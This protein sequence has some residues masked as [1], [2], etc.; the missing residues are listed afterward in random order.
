MMRPASDRDGSIGERSAQLRLRVDQPFTTPQTAEMGY[1]ARVRD[2][3][4]GRPQAERDSVSDVVIPVGGAMF[5]ELA[6]R[7]GSYLIEAVTPSGSVLEADVEVGD[8]ET[9]AVALADDTPSPHEWL[10][11]QKVSGNLGGYAAAVVAAKARRLPMWLAIGG[12]VAVAVALAAA[13]MTFSVQ[14]KKAPA[15]A[16]NTQAEMPEGAVPAE[17]ET[18]P[19]DA[20]EGAAAAPAEP[21]DFRDEQVAVA[22]AGRPLVERDILSSPPIVRASPPRRALARP[23]RAPAAAPPETDASSEPALTVPAP[24]PPP[25]ASGSGAPPPAAGP[26]GEA[27]S[28]APPPEIVQLDQST[29]LP[30]WMWLAALALLATGGGGTVL[31]RRGMIPGLAG[32]ATQAAG[33]PTTAGSIFKSA[34]PEGAPRAAESVAAAAS[35][36]GRLTLLTLPTGA[37]EWSMLLAALEGRAALAEAY[38]LAAHDANRRLQPEGADARWSTYA[39]LP[40]TGADH[41][42]PLWA[43]DNPTGGR[44]EAVRL[45]ECWVVPETGEVVAVEILTAAEGNDERVGA[46]VR[47]PYYGTLLGYLAGGRLPEAKALLNHAAEALFGKAINPY[48]AAAGGYVLVGS[49]TSYDDAPWRGW[50]Q[51]LDAAHPWLPDA[52]VLQAV[53]M[54]QTR[55]EGIRAK[56]L[57]AMDRGVPVYTEGLKRL[58]DVLT[59]LIE[60]PDPDGRLARSLDA[61]SRLAG[62]CNP[63]QVFTALRLGA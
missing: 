28:V 37:G 13:A 6:V 24:P 20:S 23:G 45:P 4:P 19:Q 40:L 61:V 50:L 3:T 57:E 35:S 32:A 41:G 29:G 25:E 36:P 8:G 59:L 39:T 15:P 21:S 44:A 52:A 11:W 31:A 26:P 2:V 5:R 1:V 53:S 51:N 56:A 63:Q 49:A 47:D 42:R 30:W 60:Q 9:Q 7:P 58:R 34:L 62:R 46:A 12:G 27:P 55:Q 14:S 22:P 10:G 48:L 18:V 17:T 38:A 54:V 16:V 33:P 43:V